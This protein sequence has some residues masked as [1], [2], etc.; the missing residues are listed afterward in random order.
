MEKWERV[1]LVMDHFGLNKNSFSREIGNSSNVTISR[2]INEK[3]TPSIATLNK[4]AERFEVN[5]DWLKFGSGDMFNT[6]ENSKTKTF[7]VLSN[8]ASADILDYIISDPNKFKDENRLDTILALFY[9]NRKDSKMEE[10]D[11]KLD[12][13]NDMMDK[14]EKRLES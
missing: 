7:E 12:K 9:N 14:L 2:L 3:R 4:I 8:I 1:K 6:V 10:L 11:K 13:V 5:L